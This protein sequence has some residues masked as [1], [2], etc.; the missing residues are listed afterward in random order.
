MHRVI[1][2][3]LPGN[4]LHFQSGS[5][6]D[7]VEQLP[8]VDGIA[9]RAGCYHFQPDRIPR[10]CFRRKFRNCLCRLIDRARLENMRFVEALP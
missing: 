2:L 9:R 3:L 1:R 5:Q 8:L 4:D 7:G 6:F 10:T